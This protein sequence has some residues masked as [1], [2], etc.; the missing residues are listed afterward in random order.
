MILSAENES[1]I[2]IVEITKP[3]LRI[4]RLNS[5]VC[6]REKRSNNTSIKIKI[7]KKSSKKIEFTDFIEVKSVVVKISNTQFPSDMSARKAIVG[8]KTVANIFFTL[9]CDLVL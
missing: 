1:F 6:K 9:M 2:R 4:T 7:V 5:S 8:T 3:E